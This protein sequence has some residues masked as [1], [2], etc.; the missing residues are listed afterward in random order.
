MTMESIL[1]LTHVDESG[2]AL[3]R[4]SL[5]AVTAGKRLAARLSAS[6]TIGI[7]AAD[8]DSVGRSSR[9]NQCS[10]ARRLR[11]SLRTG[12]L[13]HR[14]RRM[15]SSLPRRASHH[16]ARALQFA[17]RARGCGRSPSPGRRD[18]H[19]HHRDRRHGD[20]VQATRWFYRQRIEAVLSRERRPWFLLLDAGA[21]AAYA[22]APGPVTVEQISVELPPLR[23]TVT[24]FRT[25]AQGRARPFAPMRSCSSSPA[26]AG[27][28][29]SPTDSP[30][31]RGGATDPQ[32]PSCLRRIAGQQQVARRPGRR[33]P[34][35]ASLPHPPEPDR[36]DRRNAAPPQGPLHLLSRRRATR[37]GL[38]IHRRAPRH[39]A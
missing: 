38:A 39:L 11:R 20:C 5:E 28:R 8:A 2:S 27:P 30:R 14:R 9:W 24:G 33:R 37:R 25:P 22:S 31:G 32:I 19:A 16:R 3:T 35:R 21:C 29:S 36:P 7:V 34:V 17:L 1:V 4:G 6:L 13:C 26:R 10:P 15:R 23:T 12:A 18:R